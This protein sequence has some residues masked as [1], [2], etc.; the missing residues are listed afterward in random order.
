MNG[1]IRVADDASIF[2]LDRLV[3]FNDLRLAGDNNPPGGWDLYI[4]P[5]GRIGHR[6]IYGNSN[7]TIRN[8]GHTYAFVVEKADGTTLLAVQDDGRLAAAG[9][10]NIGDFRNM[11][12]NQSTGEIGWDTSS[13]RYKENITPLEDDFARVLSLQ[14]KTYTRI[15]GDPNR[16]EIGYLAEEVHDLGLH[17]L[18]EYDLQGR[19]DGVNYEK[20]VL[21]L[22]EVIKQQ[23]A[24]I[25]AL[26]QRVSE[27]E[28]RKPSQR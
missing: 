16:W 22:N 26:E 8:T 18:V 10:R 28:A 20:M 21:Y 1:N 24:R 11:Q 27:L 9:L 6:F 19:P 2:G 23:Q 3:G 13:H 4:A 12:W 25:A 5:D 17:R 15:G 7:F 14:P